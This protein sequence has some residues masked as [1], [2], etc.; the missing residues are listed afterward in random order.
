M[1]RRFAFE[2]N[3]QFLLEKRSGLYKKYYPGASERK[4]VHGTKSSRVGRAL[5]GLGY[6]GA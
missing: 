3:V 1:S 5:L 4:I 6:C 2:C